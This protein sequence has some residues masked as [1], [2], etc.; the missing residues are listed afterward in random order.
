MQP[1]FLLACPS[2]RVARAWTPPLERP[3]AVE[4]GEPLRVRWL[5]LATLALLVVSGLGYLRTWPP[6]ATVMSASMSPTINTGD[7]VVMR[8]LPRPAQIGDIVM[9]HVPDDARTRY[10]YPPVVIHRIVAIAPDGAISTKG[11]AHKVPDP[12]TVPRAAVNESVVA[13]IPAGGQALG[14]LGS[15]LGLIWLVSG[16]ALLLLFPLVDRYRESQRRGE[17]HRD[18]LATHLAALPAQIEAAVS[19]AVAVVPVAA[20]QLVV[21]RPVRRVAAAPPPPPVLAAVPRPVVFV[22]PAP[23]V[24]PAAPPPPAVW[25]RGGSCRC[26]RP[27]WP[28]RGS[29]R[30][31]RPSRPGARSHG[32]ARREQ[33]RGVELEGGPASADSGARRAV[34]RRR[35]LTGV[36]PSK[37]AADVDRGQSHRLDAGADAGGAGASG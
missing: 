17:E 15:P 9:V 26:R 2:L 28:R 27:A 30:C 21:V 4:A 5:A 37:G 1:N 6:L 13:H 24:A 18:D 36:G 35:A 34:R 32:D 31:R 8:R 14:F 7:M 33:G 11:D 20:P 22:A 16:G 12:F 10:G 3:A 23:R 25:P 19:A 29:S